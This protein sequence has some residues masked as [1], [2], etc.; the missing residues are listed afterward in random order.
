MPDGK[1]YDD[2]T[3]ECAGQMKKML[4]MFQGRNLRL[5]PDSMLQ[6]LGACGLTLC[7]A[8]SINP[9]AKNQP[10]GS[11]YRL[12]QNTP[13]GECLCPTEAGEKAF[14]KVPPPKAFKSVFFWRA[15]YRERPIL[16]TACMPPVELTTLVTPLR[17][18]TSRLS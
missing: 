4:Q 2:G 13:G 8:T 14:C 16:M 17:A 5:G 3:L 12:W 15:C 1:T 6:I 10:A 18:S 11:T 7:C 9:P